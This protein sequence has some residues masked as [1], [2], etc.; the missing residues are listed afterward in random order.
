MKNIFLYFAISFTFGATSCKKDE[1]LEYKVVN[2]QRPNTFACK[3]TLS[4]GAG[5]T[6]LE[7]WEE[8]GKYK[9]NQ[10]V[11]KVLK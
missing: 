1:F 9:H 8:C 11:F 7:V 5:H 3:Y 4:A 10:V 2:V 6:T